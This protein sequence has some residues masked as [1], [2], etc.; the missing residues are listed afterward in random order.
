[1][2]GRIPSTKRPDTL[3]GRINSERGRINSVS[4]PD[5][6]RRRPDKLRRRPDKLSFGP[7]PDKRKTAGRILFLAGAAATA[8][9]S[10]IGPAG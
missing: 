3:R 2:K 5:K 7:I 6:L 10:L 8:L 1:M 4:K 9:L